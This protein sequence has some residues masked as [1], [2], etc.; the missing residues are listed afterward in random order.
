[1]LVVE[2]D[3]LVRRTL[4]R[5]TSWMGLEVTAVDNGTDGLALLEREPYALVITD[6]RMPGASGLEVARGAAQLATPPAVIVVSGF[7]EPADETQIQRTGAHVLHKPFD[8]AE[9]KALIERLLQ[10]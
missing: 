9:V 3:P 5:I 10:P 4:E 7:V 2:D 1:V 8:P 6:F